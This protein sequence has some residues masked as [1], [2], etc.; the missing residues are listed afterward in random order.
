MTI[1]PLTCTWE[2]ACPCPLSCN[3]SLLVSYSQDGS[4]V[5]LHAV[6]QCACVY[7]W[8]QTWVSVPR[9]WL[10]DPGYSLNAGFSSGRCNASHIT[11]VYWRKSDAI[12]LQPLIRILSAQDRWLMCT[13]LAE[14]WGAHVLLWLEGGW[15]S[16]FTACQC[17]PL[18]LLWAT[19]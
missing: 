17:W 1:I 9:C 10:S 6:P 18:F 16:C 19:W 8:R 7:S 13:C 12:K 15:G 5:I 2:G 11:V 3:L 14:G 4:A